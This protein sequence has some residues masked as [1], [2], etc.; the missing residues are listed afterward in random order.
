MIEILR[1]KVSKMSAPIEVV[2]VPG[3]KTI[4]KILKLKSKKGQNVSKGTL[5]CLYKTDSDDKVLKLKSNTTG[6]VKDVFVKEGEEC[7]A[8]CVLGFLAFIRIYNDIHS[9]VIY[10]S[11][12]LFSLNDTLLLMARL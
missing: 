11:V 12:Y 7:L 2:R 8:G 9:P 10:L 4:I 1:R 5:L 3:V 6:T